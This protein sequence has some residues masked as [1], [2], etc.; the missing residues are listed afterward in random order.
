MSVIKEDVDQEESQRT[1][2]SIDKEGG[3]SD[4][5]KEVPIHMQGPY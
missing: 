1:E 4:K 5:I 2:I 3:S